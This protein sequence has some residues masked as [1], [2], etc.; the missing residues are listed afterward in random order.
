MMILVI[1]VI[2]LCLVYKLKLG[3]NAYFNTV[4]YGTLLLG[5]LVFSLQ[6]I[7][8]CIMNAQLFNVNVRAIVGTFA[9]YFLSTFVYTWI[10]SWPIG[11]QYLLMFFCPYIAGRSLF[12]VKKFCLTIF[13]MLYFFSI[14][15][16]II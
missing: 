11:L 8:F 4:N 14:A 5:N 10:I 15:N 9:I 13:T 12:Q 3:P 1:L 7:S 16:S 2:L 6:L